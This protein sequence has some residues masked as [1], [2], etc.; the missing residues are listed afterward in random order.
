MESQN[1]GNMMNNNPNMMMN[2]NPNMMMGNNPNI[3]M[4]NNPN[5]MMNNIRPNNSR[6]GVQYDE[7][8]QKILAEL[9]RAV[10]GRLR[11]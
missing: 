3:M 1:Y 6:E 8:E 10:F 4:G 9:T 7:K 11:R 2:N 5:M